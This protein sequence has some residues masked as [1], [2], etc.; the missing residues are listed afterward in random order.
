MKKTCQN[1]AERR[2]LRLRSERQRLAE[3]VYARMGERVQW[4]L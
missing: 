2:V 1:H 4:V 3:Q